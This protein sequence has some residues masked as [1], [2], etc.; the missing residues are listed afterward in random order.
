[1]T[2]H[3][4]VKAI[5]EKAGRPMTTSEIASELNRTKLYKKRDN[6]EITTFQIH[7][8]TR[9]YPQIFNQQGAMVSLRTS[10]ENPAKQKSVPSKQDKPKKTVVDLNEKDF[11]IKQFEKNLIYQGTFRPA[12]KIDDIV[13]N[14]PGLY[15]FRIKEAGKLPGI[16]KK[17]LRSRG[18]DI[19]Y[20]GIATQS[21]R[22][23]M[24]NQELLAKGH[25]TFFR[26]IGAVLGF[27]P[28]FN[29]LAGRKNKR[30]YVFS[31]DD[32]KKIIDWLNDNL[33]VNWITF[34]GNAGLLE[35][36]LIS[37]YKPILNL[38]KNPNP[39]PELSALRKKCVN[40]ANGMG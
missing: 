12:V 26:S 28:P 3:D 10:Q 8:R 5:L 20:I 17:E 15:C 27:C 14:V 37:K 2:L 31:D 39:I 24:L 1:M 40:V 16:F 9:N 13:P 22:K 7:G 11:D 30:N 23:R 25:G 32:E 38:D 6:S 4:A 21:L 35:T 29:S 33:L 34:S 19:I 36:R 18:H